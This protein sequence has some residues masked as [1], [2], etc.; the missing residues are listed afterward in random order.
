MTRRLFF[1]LLGVFGLFYGQHTYAQTLTTQP[2]PVTAVCSGSTMVVS[3]SL[4]GAVSATNVFTAQLANGE[5]SYANLTST[6]ATPSS[7]TGLFSLTA[8]IPT[9]TTAGSTYRI[10]VVGST[11]ALVGTPSPTTLTVRATPTIPVTQSIALCQRANSL[12]LTATGQNLLWYSSATGMAS[13]T[14]APVLSTSA[15]GS[16]VYYVSQTVNGCESARASL[17][18][19]VTATP[20]SPTIGQ[21]SL[22]YCQGSSVQSLTAVGLG[23]RWYTTATGGTGVGTL[24]PNTGTSGTISYFVSQSVNGCESDR[25]S[26]TVTTSAVPV[27]PAV[28]GQITLCQR[29]TPT[30]LTATGQSLRWYPAATGSVSSTIAPVPSTDNIGATSYFV[31]QTVGICES[32]RSQIRVTIQQLPGLPTTSN[33]TVCQ[34]S[35][36]VTLSATGQAIRWYATPISTEVLPNAPTVNTTQAVVTIF[37]VTQTVDACESPRAEARVLVRPL[38]LPPTPTPTNY[39]QFVRAQPLSATGSGT[40]RWFAPDGTPL[41]S[42]PTPPTDQ[43]ASFSYLVSQLVDGCEGGR[44]VA[45]VNILTSAPPTVAQPIVPVC[46]GLP[47]QPLQASGR[48]LRWTDPFGNV[49]SAAPVPSTQS[50]TTNAD[51]L[52]YYVT[53]TGENGCESPRVPIRVFVVPLPTLSLSGPSSVNLG[54][55]APLRLTFTGISPYQYRLSSGQSGTA[56]KDTTILVLPTRTTTYQVQEIRNQCGLGTGG[57]LATV[58]VNIPVI[59]TL[60]LTNS[61]VCVGGIVSMAFSA[62]GP[63]NAGSQFRVQYARAQ[64]DTTQAQFVDALSS[65]PPTGGQI[66]GTLPITLTAG[67]YW[68][69]VMATNPKIPVNGTISPT[70]LTVRPLPTATIAGTQAIYETQAAN[71]S[72]AFTGD[73]PWE[74]T[75]RDSSSVG[76]VTRQ[77]QTAANPHILEVRPLRTTTYILSSISNGCGNGPRPNS[78]ATVTV[79]PLLG[80]E[81]QSLNETLTIFPMPVSSGFTLRIEG[82]T[83]GETALLELVSSTG[84]SVWQGQ[85]RQSETIVSLA[86]KAGGVYV[87]KVKIGE[88]VASRR[89]VKL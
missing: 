53:Q 74:L 3:F 40:L 30:A 15:V 70:T 14:L 23:L 41:G 6:T 69:R 10:R 19:V 57:N 26:L 36:A 21:T 35:P 45:V 55:D 8:T 63:F 54:I 11:T 20:G 33:P 80:L 4:T 43:P 49:T 85:T 82:L 62:T 64:G 67:T 88:R 37:Y 77:L 78:L 5:G 17:S 34:N 50:A 71:L 47:A 76:G 89:V 2:L 7:T 48:G 27:T 44:A 12:T 87:L 38:P 66:G 83:L 18:A 61:T 28:T 72:I 79:N 24:T 52:V 42:A 58:N 29:T 59:Q 9:S 39:C 31:T 25:S 68:V 75:Y 84:Q 46:Q 56:T 86:G 81:D 13:T 22:T 60:N 51:G 73:G 32:D 16:S 65:S 1:A